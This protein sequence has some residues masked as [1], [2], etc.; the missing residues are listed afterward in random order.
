MKQ[1]FLLIV[2]TTFL[3]AALFAQQKKHFK[4]SAGPEIGYTANGNIILWGTG[5]GGSVQAEYFFSEKISATLLAGYTSYLGVSIYGGYKPP[6]LNAVPIR[7]GGRYYFTDRLYLAAQAGVGL[8]SGGSYLLKAKPTSF[9]YSPQAGYL[10]KINK[11]NRIDL[12]I[13]YENFYYGTKDGNPSSDN[14]NS[15]GVRLAYIF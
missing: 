13:K 11:I 9:S 15:I 14:F 6:A 12:A 3:S 10:F 8:L 7:L 2:S 1:L 4:C 5:I